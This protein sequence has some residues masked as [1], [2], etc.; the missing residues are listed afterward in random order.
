MALTWIAGWTAGVLA[1]R[2]ETDAFGDVVD[3]GMGSGTRPRHGTGRWSS[4]ANFTH[5]V[6]WAAVMGT[7]GTPSSTAALGGEVSVLGVVAA[8]VD[9]VVEAAHVELQAATT[10]TSTSAHDE[11]FTPTRR[12]HGRPSSG[13]PDCRMSIATSS[14][15][16]SADCAISS[17]WRCSAYRVVNRTCG[18]GRLRG[19]LIGC[20]SAL[21]LVTKTF[22][23]RAEIATRSNVSI[24]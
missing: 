9:V 12:R 13:R 21:R 4:S 1:E 2:A 20:E 5:S 11:R 7:S 23:L 24:V 17:E 19:R 16:G 14:G 3:T 18:P 22:V 6:R 10:K 15:A 8:W